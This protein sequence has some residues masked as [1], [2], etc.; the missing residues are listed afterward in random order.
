MNTESKKK[1]IINVAYIVTV[2]AVLYFIF[3]YMIHWI[4]P[5]VIG[6]LIASSLKPIVKVITKN[7]QIKL[8]NVAI[9]VISSFY[10]VVGIFL[11][12]FISFLWSQT[13]EFVY[14]LPKFYFENVEPI[15]FNINYWLV[16]RASE[17]SPELSKT[18]ADI[19]QNL[20]NYLATAIKNI[21]MFLVHLATEMIS[22]FPLYL[23]S[24]IFTIV[25]SV[26][27]S[28]NYYEITTFI[29]KQLPEKFNSTFSEAKS[30]ISGTLLKMI[31]AYAI[32]CCITFFE[33]LIGLT[34]LNVEYR[35]PIAA[36][37]AVLDILPVLGTGGVIIPWAII[38]LISKDYITGL[39]LLGLYVT[40]TV[41]RNIV[42]PRIVGKQI[43]LHPII[44]I[45]AMYAGLRLFGFVGFISAPMVAILVKYLNDSGKIHLYK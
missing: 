26:F 9:F 12:F 13:F 29:K 23:I 42:E 32:I 39:G 21:S 24:I 18:I 5:F 41:V 22:N 16:D 45:T 37:V 25:L 33:L 30:F 14:A 7:T 31:K 28:T 15:L 27:I 44:T 35:V 38:E 40:V 19:I 34:L 20:I 6:F 2:Y 43:G 8:K 4:M 17:L 36:I 3:K 11:W 10:V 1:F